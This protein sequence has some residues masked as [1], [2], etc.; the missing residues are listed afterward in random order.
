MNFQGVVMNVADLD[1]S[2][3]FYHEVLDFTLVS[4]KEQLAALGAPGT[5]RAQ[6]IVLRVLGRSPLAGGGHIGLRAF[7]LEVEAADELER[8]ATDLEARNAL[9]TRREHQEWTALIG[10]DPDMAAVVVVWHPGERATIEDSWK[11]LDD[12]LYGIGE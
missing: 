8:I 1:R 2:I 9:V 3:D 4:R 5:D 12:L 6:I 10:R 7:M 11:T